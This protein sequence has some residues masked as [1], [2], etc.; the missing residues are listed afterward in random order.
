MLFRSETLDDQSID[1]QPKGE[2]PFGHSTESLGHGH[3]DVLPTEVADNRSST[4]HN[5]SAPSTK[6]G[7]QF[8]LQY[9]KVPHQDN[10]Q[11]FTGF[12]QRDG[13]SVHQPS[14]GYP[15]WHRPQ[16]DASKSPFNQQQ[17]P[18]SRPADPK[19]H[20]P[21]RTFTP[22]DLK[23]QRAIKVNASKS[24]GRTQTSTPFWGS[25][26]NIHGA[27]FFGK[28]ASSSDEHPPPRGSPKGSKDGS[29]DSSS[30]QNNGGEDDGE[31]SHRDPDG[32]E[33]RPTPTEEH[34]GPHYD[35][36]EDPNPEDPSRSQPPGTNGS[37]PGLIV[38]FKP[39]KKDY[40][41]LKNDEGYPKWKT[42]MRI[43]L[44][45]H[46]LQVVYDLE[47]RA[48][49]V[50]DFNTW[51]QIQRWLYMILSANVQTFHGRSIV[52][53]FLEQLCATSTL[54]ALDDHYS[55]S[56]AGR[57][58]AAQL[59]AYLTGTDLDS[60]W[61]KPLAQFITD[62]LLKAEQYNEMCDPTA[63][64]HDDS[65]KHMLQRAVHPIPALRQVV[66]QEYL[67]LAKGEPPLAFR[68][69]Y[70]LL[71]STAITQ[72][73]ASGRRRA[74]VT[75]L[76]RSTGDESD[77]DEEN[78]ISRLVHNVETRPR[79]P[80]SVFADFTPE[81]RKQWIGLSKQG[82]QRI[83]DLFAKASRRANSTLLVETAP[84]EESPAPAAEESS[85]E[86]DEVTTVVANQAKTESSSPT[87]SSNAHPG[88]VRRMMAQKSQTKSSKTTKRKATAATLRHV[89]ATRFT[90]PD[91]DSESSLGLGDLPDD[92]DFSREDSDGG[93]QLT[94]L[95]DETL[96]GRMA[97]LTAMETHEPDT[98]T[99]PAML[100]AFQT[101]AT[102]TTDYEDS[103]DSVSSGD[104][105]IWCDTRNSYYDS[106]DF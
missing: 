63:Q 89:G 27:S 26:Q 5:H 78:T 91:S 52:R 88:D 64:L 94:P 101:L 31:G 92:D 70:S 57:I 9:E 3:D 24:T 100:S 83:V 103:H 102:Y 33:P 105:S 6:K 43:A 84:D 8:P 28:N 87:S 37:G 80:D 45:A 71:L 23:D 38:K 95:Y 40:P 90:E 16:L 79:L 32:H 47:H 82:K 58:Y 55:T 48:P 12:Q 11:V 44:H 35:P 51:R 93:P 10:Q 104:E 30:S 56:T 66:S 97:M 4:R 75:L 14:K 99:D 19:T 25:P 18:S 41:I 53:R 86:S 2:L 67:S 15:S 49:T 72:D 54:Y 1:R 106:L 61:N 46:G 65:L 17:R 21:F 60:S 98:I 20:D 85:A 76:T 96:E 29:S 13:Y 73:T 42:D 74:N 36:P 39:D 77:S 7:G 81:D 69:Y 50:A 68:D 62:W 59:L 34:G 22:R